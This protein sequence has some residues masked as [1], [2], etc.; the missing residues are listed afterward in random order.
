[1]Y[2]IHG[3]G[4]SVLLFN[5]LV[6]NLHPEQP[7]FGLQAKG[8]N[9]MDDNLDKMEDIAADYIKEILKQN[10]E[11]PYALCGYSFGGLITFE[12]GKQLK[13]MGKKVSMLGMFDSYAYES[14]YYKPWLTKVS[15]KT[16]EF[17]MRVIYAFVFM[18][19][20]PKIVITNKIRFAKILLRPVL[21]KITFR[22]QKGSFLP[23]G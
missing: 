6:K 20:E 2:L 10:P 4:L 15:I 16:Y 8:L 14:I 7:V 23:L 1:M 13:A 21:E 9:G 19:K 12:M 3:A 17:F 11:G 22:K 5:S 18:T